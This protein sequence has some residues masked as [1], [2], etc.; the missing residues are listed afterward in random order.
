MLKFRITLTI[1]LL[2]FAFNTSF[3]QLDG[4]VITAWNDTIHGKIDNPFND[5]KS[6]KRVKIELEDGK[7][8]R[9]TPHDAI[10]YYDGLY[11]YIKH[12][13]V[14][15]KVLVTGEVK[16]LEFDHAEMAGAVLSMGTQG[17]GFQGMSPT[18]STFKTTVMIL[19]NNDLVELR[20]Q[21]TDSNRITLFEKKNSKK[22]P[23]A[24]QIIFS[25]APEIHEK[26]QQDH[27]MPYHQIVSN[28]NL[29]LRR[30]P[31]VSSKVA[32]Y[33]NEDE[34]NILLFRRGQQIDNIQGK[35]T[36]TINGKKVGQIDVGEYL[37]LTLSTAEFYT[38]R[39]KSKK[40][41]FK[42][43]LYGRK[44][45]VMPLEIATGNI[46]VVYPIDSKEAEKHLET[47]K[48]VNAK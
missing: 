30:K 13:S 23:L 17:Q 27:R 35:Y 12:G 48:E 34:V 36:I 7:T 4:Y 28:Y 14:F 47:D 15:A 26:I 38:L 19:P 16:L 24:D 25:D 1:T 9:F 11:R 5:I 20:R 3:A 18:S 32:A 8:R 45:H 29:F 21:S 37:P 6:S 44:D 2:L 46:T 22:H 43:S 33:Q 41:K 31:E 40:G 10:A 39:I 42:Y